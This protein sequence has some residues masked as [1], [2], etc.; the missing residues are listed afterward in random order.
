MDTPAAIPPAT[1]AAIPTAARPIWNERAPTLMV[2]S[3]TAES[4]AWAASAPPA[5]AL[6]TPA[7]AAATSA[8]AS[9]TITYS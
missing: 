5:M 3:A 2:V 8:S 1:A 4:I 9:L 7:V 6:V